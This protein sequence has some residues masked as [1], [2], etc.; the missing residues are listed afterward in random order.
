MGVFTPD[1]QL[2]QSWF[3][4]ETSALDRAAMGG[5]SCAN[6]R[7]V[8]EAEGLQGGARAAFLIS[9]RCRCNAGNNANSRCADQ[10]KL[11]DACAAA[12]RT[13]FRDEAEYVAERR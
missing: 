9:H 5:R 3:V 13:P 1:R 2:T 8:A 6:L 10:E 11:A 12:G 7:E 4:E